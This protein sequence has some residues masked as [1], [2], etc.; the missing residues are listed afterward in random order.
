M[1]TSSSL[2]IWIFLYGADKLISIL[3]ASG[4]GENNFNLE[5]ALDSAQTNLPKQFT[6]YYFRKYFLKPVT[7]GSHTLELYILTN[8]LRSIY[9]V[10]K[11][12]LI[13]MQYFSSL[14][15]GGKAVHS[16]YMVSYR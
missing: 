11:G 15:R 2:Q 12:P 5:I 3:F 6:V 10:S 13:F 8:L 16:D 7:A 4:S 9:K 14:E 1:I